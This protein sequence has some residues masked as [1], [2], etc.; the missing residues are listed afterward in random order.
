MTLL[1][2]QLDSHCSSHDDGYIPHHLRLSGL[3]NLIHNN[4]KAR[5]SNFAAPRLHKLDGMEPVWNLVDKDELP[6]CHVQGYEPRILRIEQGR[7]RREHGTSFRDNR[8]ESSTTQFGSRNNNHTNNS[9]FHDQVPFNSRYGNGGK[10]P[11]DSATGRPIRPDQRRRPFLP[12]VICAACKRTGHE[13]SSCDMLAIAIFVE[14]HRNSLSDGEKSA[15]E[16]RWI[17]RWK[18]KIG[19]PTRTPRQVM[20]A[21]C[22]ELDISPDH[23]AQDIDWDCWPISDDSSVDSK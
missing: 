19:Q 5:V 16:D 22:E 4:A 17:L 21:Y 7:D 13:A 2:A 3:A 1:Q 11:S 10:R 8:R 6:F 9:G 18:D 23:L 12:G 15:I 20:W 14:K